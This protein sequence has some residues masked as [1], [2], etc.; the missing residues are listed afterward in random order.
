MT[1]TFK[2]NENANI[3]NLLKDLNKKGNNWWTRLNE[4]ADIYIDIRKDDTINIYH[5]GGSILKINNA[6]SAKINY[7]YLP[8][9]ENNTYATCDIADNKIKLKKDIK[10]E[11]DDLNKKKIAQIKKLIENYYPNDSE[12]GIQGAYATVW[13]KDEGKEQKEKLEKFGFFIDT[14]LQYSKN[15]RID[16]IYLYYENPDEPKLYFVELK[17]KGDDRLWDNTCNSTESKEN[18]CEQLKKYKNFIN[19]NKTDIINYYKTLY[20]IK[21]DLKLIPEDAKSIN[22]KN[23]TIENRPILLIGDA[24]NNFIYKD[25]KCKIKEP[26]LS[27]EMENLKSRIEAKDYACMIICRGKGTH[28]LNFSCTNS[29]NVFMIN[30]NKNK[31][32]NNKCQN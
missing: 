8:A 23:L 6:Q 19:K 12:K 27:I 26:K 14:E 15:G 5:N 30:P 28:T 11:L 10:V 21:K 7:A 18:I 13:K 17:T 31:R 20:N 22:I 1:N 32:K 25:G 2:L 24:T 29:R 3:Y 4:D 9:G 16:L